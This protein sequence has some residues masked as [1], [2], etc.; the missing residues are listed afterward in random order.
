MHVFSDWVMSREEL[1]LFCIFCICIPFQYDRVGEGS[2][3]VCVCG[4]GGGAGWIFGRL[5]P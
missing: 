1:C 3:C 5:L 4:G 2:V